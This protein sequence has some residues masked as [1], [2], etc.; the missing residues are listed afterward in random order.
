MRRFNSVIIFLFLILFAFPNF[1]S[2]QY[3]KLKRKINRIVSDENLKDGFAGILIYDLSRNRTVYSYNSEKLFTPAS[4]QKILTTAAA[5]YFLPKNYEFSTYVR[6]TGP[7]VDSVLYGD[8]VIKGTGD[9]LFTTDDLFALVDS[10]K[11]VGIKLVKGK[12]IG[13]VGWCDSLY[14]GSGWMWDDAYY[15]FMP[16]LSPLILNKARLKIEVK[17]TKPNRLAS[18]NFLDSLSD[19]PLANYVLTIKEDSSNFDVYRNYLKHKNSFYSDGFISASAKPDTST[20]NII[21]PDL[22]FLRT[23]R[24]ICKNNNIKITGATE[25]RRNVPYVSELFGISHSLDSVIV[26]TNKESENINAEMLLR[27][28]AAEYYG[29][30]A[31]AQNGIKMID[32]LISLS[33]NTPRNFI[34]VDGSGLSRYNL[35]SPKLI[36]D[37]FKFLRKK[38]PQKFNAL[39]NSFPVAG[40]DGTLQKRMTNGK[41]FKNVQA[42]TGTMTAVSALSGIVKNRRGRKFLF[43]MMMQNY[44]A[45]TSSIRKLQ[46]KIC[47]S[48]AR[49]K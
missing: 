30:P 24:K 34:L 31:T 9:P 42:K 32:S 48:L 17:P 20:L 16:Y 2:A 13:D 14:F 15:G 28:L 7:V 49:S 46:D 22:Y 27:A 1:S 3:R 12:L 33:G 19:F 40:L 41:A 37:V 11:R 45:K 4:N 36:V 29:E 44:S 5:L 35:I 8:I 26:E 18:V 39:I 10:V 21:N 43:S 25:L 6:I 23:F 38:S 47:E